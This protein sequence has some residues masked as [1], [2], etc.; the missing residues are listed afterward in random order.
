M[1][2][3][4]KTYAAFT[5]V[6]N[7][8]ITDFN[9]IYD[10]IKVRTGANDTDMK[11]DTTG[12][13]TS[14]Y[15]G[16]ITNKL[17]SISGITDG[18]TGKHIDPVI[19][20]YFD[21]YTGKPV[22]VNLEEDGNVSISVGI[23]NKGY[24]GTEAT[25]TGSLA[26]QN[27][28]LT[29]TINGKENITKVEATEGKG[30]YWHVA[31]KAGKVLGVV[32]VDV[33]SYAPSITEVTNGV[34]ATASVGLF[35]SDGINNNVLAAVPENDDV[36]NYVSFKMKAAG[37]FNG[38]V[39]PVLGK[40]DFTAGYFEAAPV[41]G[42]TK[43]GY[44]ISGDATSTDQEFFIK[45]GTISNVKVAV[46]ELEFNDN[47]GN[48]GTSEALGDAEAAKYYKLTASIA[49][50]TITGDT[51]A[52]FV[53]TGNGTQIGNLSA[54]SKDFYVKKGAVE[55][56][57]VNVSL[58]AESANVN[59]TSTDSDAYTV[60]V[61]R[62]SAETAET[63]GNYSDG[64]LKA[65][66]YTVSTTVPEKVLK[67]ARGAVKINNTLNG[68]SYAG[69]G[70]GLLVQNIPGN[71][72]DYYV[73]TPT[74]ALT[75]AVNTGASKEG[76]IVPS[77]KTV[78]HN[79]FAG[80]ASPLYL[81]KGKVNHTTD[82][83][84]NNT[85][86]SA[87]NIFTS[88]KPSKGDYWTL[89]TK[90]NVTA[91]EGY[92]T[93]GDI[94]KGDEKS[95]YLPKAVVEYVSNS[96]G[97]KFVQVKSAGYLPSGT[98]EA[99]EGKID[100]A[101]VS[102]DI[103]T[104]T[105]ENII[106]TSGT[107]GDYKLTIAKA[108]ATDAGYISGAAGEGTVALSTEYYIA[109]GSVASQASIDSIV[110]SDIARATG[111]GA[112]GFEFNVTASGSAG[113]PTITAGYITSSD[114]K[115]TKPT[116]KVVKMTLPEAKL[117][118]TLTGEAA[119]AGATLSNGLLAGDNTSKYFVTPTLANATVK[120]TVESAGYVDAASSSNEITI[121][122]ND[123]NRDVA[124]IKTGT[125]KQFTT[126]ALDLSGKLSSNFNSTVS[127]DYT[128]SLAG[129][130]SFTGTLDTGYYGEAEKTIG[131]ERSL[132]GSYTVAHGSVS[133]NTTAVT[134]GT[135]TSGD[136]SLVTAPGKPAD[137]AAITVPVSSVAISFNT[138]KPGYIKDSDV[139]NNTA[140]TGSTTI[141]L[142]KYEN[143][144]DKA[145]V[146]S[147]PTTSDAVNGGTTKIVYTPVPNGITDTTILHT[148]GRYLK[149]NVKVT[150]HVDAI[151]L[152]AET[153]LKKLQDRLAGTLIRG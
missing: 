66:H 7:K 30:A 20:P 26:A 40:T 108:S 114:V 122:I 125:T 96:T 15:A 90:C 50:G 35:G 70:A 10:A 121:E 153:D 151:G 59:I 130:D 132:T 64:Y 93:A 19:T 41:L 123:S 54:I 129:T 92:I 3:E 37:S 116:D 68:I 86:N 149:H 6:I 126:N 72:D 18:G 46:T 33:G 82:I 32:D 91:N 110:K 9:S 42:I 143:S 43:E 148:E 56:S 120:A 12:I 55:N 28:A 146:G 147:V 45:K 97:A 128:I 25:L 83:T 136:V 99:I 47:G 109:K 16:L 57:A 36:A 144:E 8:A 131:V 84:I 107:T 51:T 1:A 89:T 14:E 17:F 152:N 65:G 103:G 60:T 115:L 94:V 138:V 104:E 67:I 85:V 74:V 29:G 34:S 76:Y 111:A 13:A 117:A 52:G 78:T 135:A 140:A 77:D 79:E 24:Y 75:S 62:D 21:S 2:D 48:I 119:H 61:K 23:P 141:Y 139:T 112:S 22:A 88:T 127:G 95:Y 11:T 38:K 4:K 39:T 100:Y 118:A 31:P 58:V 80:T 5:G 113:T 27:V 87:A 71:V 98:I 81:K 134:L 133:V 73:I 69:T 150:L 142:K 145:E 105:G 102:V 49:G 124:Y 137:F 101:A 106:K 63:T 53:P 44:D